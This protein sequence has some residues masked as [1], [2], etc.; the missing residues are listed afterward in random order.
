MIHLSVGG[1]DW[2]LSLIA[3]EGIYACPGHIQAN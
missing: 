3:D 1:G 2:T